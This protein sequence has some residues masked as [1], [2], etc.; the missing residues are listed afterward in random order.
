MKKKLIIMIMALSLSIVTASCGEKESDVSNEQSSQKIEEE[1]E[2]EPDE[3][4]KEGNE[5]LESL[6]DIDVDEGVFDVELTMPADLVGE[7][8]QEELD[9]DAAEYGYKVTLNDDGSATYT[10]TK[11]QHRKILEDMKE[12]FNQELNKMIGSEDY[13]NFTKIEVNDNFTEFTVT[14]KSTELDLN[15]SFST[16][17]FYMYGGMYNVFSGDDVDNVSVTFVNSD[18]GEVIETANSSDMGE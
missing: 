8:T 16:I 11:S 4:S 7:T 1:P 14:T 9:K 10:M 3:E 15:E 17:A 12:S 5:D 6:G 13:P 18:S 2:K